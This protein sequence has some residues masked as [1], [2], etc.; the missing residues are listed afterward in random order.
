M[1]VSQQ[2]YEKEFLDE[3]SKKQ[4]YLKTCEWVAKNLLSKTSKV[5]VSKITWRITDAEKDLPTYKLELFVT[6]DED[7]INNNM[8]EV[9]KQ[10]HSAFYSNKT[11]TCGNCNK[12]AYR[13]K[14]QQK[15]D[16]GC[17]WFK[18]QVSKV[19]DSYN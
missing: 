15:L 3:N 17:G 12:D 4:A 8:C 7:E 13:K 14:M 16:T 9:C 19:L 18:E 1:Q 6:Y 10:M 5:E 2:F 11:Y